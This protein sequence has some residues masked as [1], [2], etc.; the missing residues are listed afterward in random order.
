MRDYWGMLSSP[1]LPSFPGVVAPDRILSIGQIG[2]ESVL[3]LN[4]IV[5]KKTVYLYEN[6][7][8]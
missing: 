8:K 4:R 2:L 6:G 3:M 5:R 7:Y 1:L